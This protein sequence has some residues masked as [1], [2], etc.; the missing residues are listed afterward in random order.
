MNMEQMVGL[1]GMFVGI[2]FG[3][4]GLWWGRKKALMNRGIDERFQVISNKSQSTSWKITLGTICFLFA[5]HIVGAQISTVATLGILLLIH[6][7][8]WALSTFYYNHKY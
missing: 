2:A 4:I 6:M 8:G 3:V 5:L 1:L 7:A